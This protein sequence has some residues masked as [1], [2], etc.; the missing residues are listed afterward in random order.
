MHV[1]AAVVIALA[2]GCTTLGPMPT[3][4]AVSAIPAGRVGGEV[5]IGAAPAYHLSAA[6]SR[7]KGGAVGQAAL[8]LEPDRLLGVP[9]L[10]VGGRLFGQSGDAP[11]EAMI[12]YRRALDDEFAIAVVGYGTSKRAT[13]KLASYHGF[14]MGTEVA[15]DGLIVGF[16]RWLGLHAQGAASITRIVASGKY[17]VDSEGIGQDC[18]EDMPETNTFTS[19]QIRGWYPSVTASLSLDVGRN[20]SSWFHSF[21][22]ALMMSSGRMPRVVGGV[23]TDD[24]TYFAYGATAT[25]GLGD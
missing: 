13:S 17:C 20:G 18:S 10:I 7:P 9:G 2:S 22:F 14:R 8:L 23:Q 16:T 21:R 11:V 5:Q 15:A 6:A 25:L 24:H 3:T 12:G 1:L 4:T 19:G